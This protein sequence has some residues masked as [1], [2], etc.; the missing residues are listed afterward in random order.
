MSCVIMS[1]SSDYNLD[2]F[3]R[4]E[5]SYIIVI[6]GYIVKRLNFRVCPI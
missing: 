5:I 6:N 4:K 1:Q 2:F 3:V